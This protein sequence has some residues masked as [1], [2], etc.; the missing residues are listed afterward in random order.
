MRVHHGRNKTY[1]YKPQSRGQKAVQKKSNLSWTKKFFALGCLVVVGALLFPYEF[2]QDSKS[3]WDKLLHRM[4]LQVQQI[5]THG[6]DRVSTDQ[7]IDASGIAKGE[8]IYDLN[9]AEI[10]AEIEK[11]SWVE[12]ATIERRLP[13]TINIYIDERTPKA[14]F[15]H[16]NKFSLVDE[17][18]NIL[19]DVESPQEGYILIQ[20][21]E[22]NTEFST[23]LDELYEIEEI[24]SN[25]ESLTRLGKRRWD[26]KIK[27]GAVIKLPESNSPAAIAELKK[28]I[29]ENNVLSFQCMIDLRFTP[30]KIYV[31]F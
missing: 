22:A 27:N 3:Q 13:S 18:G 7:I 9:L 2:L 14:V 6:N 25:I 12:K 8:N 24:Y 21:K 26:V 31:R 4:D 20:G 15:F 16:H 17:A 1:S 10:K 5:N 29:Q 23:V 28:L 30:D 11:F 19:D